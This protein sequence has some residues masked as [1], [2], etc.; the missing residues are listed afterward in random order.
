MTNEEKIKYRFFKVSVNIFFFRMYSDTNVF[1]IKNNATIVL[2]GIWY[3]LI[4]LL[5][6]WWGGSISKPFSSIRNT[7]EAIHINLTGGIDLSQE[8]EEAE[9]DD[10]TNYIWKNLLRKTTAIINK[11]ELEIIIDIQSE[12]DQLNKEKYSKENIDYITF[13]LKKIDINSLKF[14]EIEDVFDAMKSHERNVKE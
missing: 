3:S 11:K 1:T 14:E 6:G 10:I 7:M 12:F 2:L 13:N 5:F 8:M 9:Y 4:S